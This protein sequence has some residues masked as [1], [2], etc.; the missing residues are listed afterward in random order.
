M[1][2]KILGGNRKRKQ[3]WIKRCFKFFPKCGKTFPIFPL[4]QLHKMSAS[5]PKM[6]KNSKTLTPQ[7]VIPKRLRAKVCSD[8]QNFGGKQKRETRMD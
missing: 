3:E 1:T 5:G 8:P 6:T 4:G 2:P 7:I